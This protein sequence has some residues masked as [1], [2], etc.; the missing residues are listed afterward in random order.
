MKMDGGFC[1]FDG[2]FHREIETPVDTRLFNTGIVVR[3][4]VRTRGTR[5]AFFTEHYESLQSRLNIL[6]ISLEEI[7]GA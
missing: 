3:E 7:L 6:H 2:F 1:W 5:M 4:E